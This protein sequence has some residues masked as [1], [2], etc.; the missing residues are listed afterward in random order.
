MV[1]E[2]RHLLWAFKLLESAE[3][4]WRKLNAPQLV[5]LVYAGVRF[6]DGVERKST[7]ERDAA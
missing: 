3:K 7:A 6:E 1:R 2:A 5:E 4:R